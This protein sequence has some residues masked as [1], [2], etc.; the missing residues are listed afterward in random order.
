MW[1]GPRN[2]S[3]T[4]MRSFENRQDCRVID[5]PLYA[6][7]LTHTG[8]VHPMQEE[9]LASQ[10][11]DWKE[12]VD[13][14]ITARPAP[15][16]FQKQMTHHITDEISLD[17]LRHLDHFFLIRDPRRMAASYADRM[18]EV[19]PQALGLEQEVRL[20][21]FV[22]D[23]KGHRPPVL[24]AQDVLSDPEGMLK[25]LCAHLDLSFDQAMLSW[26]SGRRQSDGVWAPHWYAS[27]E[28]STGFLPVRHELPDLDPQGAETAEICMPFYEK[29]YSHRLTPDR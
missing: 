3:T 16:W 15:V 28:R 11:K 25:K 26:P 21:E 24:D 5:E 4:M 14:L 23:I 22:C 13:H 2:I 10:P 8:H 9:I 17:W 6:Y 12:A 19:S 7:Y 18:G 27:V 1:S 29:L 20:Y